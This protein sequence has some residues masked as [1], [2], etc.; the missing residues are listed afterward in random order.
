MQTVTLTTRQKNV[1]GTVFDETGKPLPGVLVDVAFQNRTLTD[2]EGK[3][4]LVF[5]AEVKDSEDQTLQVRFR[6]PVELSS[7]PA[8]FAKLW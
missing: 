5:D 8:Q 2:T 4:Q 3:Y 7:A 6:P 1:S